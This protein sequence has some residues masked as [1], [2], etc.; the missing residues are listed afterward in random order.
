MD[1]QAAVSSLDLSIASMQKI[2][3]DNHPCKDAEML[4]SVQVVFTMLSIFCE[5]E[6]L[7]E[8]FVSIER[9]VNSIYDRPPEHSLP[10]P[11][12]SQ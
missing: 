2:L 10:T 3:A 4:G 11:N 5:H 8:R 7:K 6:A 1:F 9:L 12:V